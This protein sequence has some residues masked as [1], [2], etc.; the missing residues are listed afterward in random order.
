MQI[1]LL[2]IKFIFSL[3]L[4][5]RRGIA[6]LYLSAIVVIS[7]MPARDL[8]HI[9]IFPSFDKLAHFSMYFGLSFLAC[10]SLDLSRIRMGPIY[11]LL[12]GVFMWGVLMEILQRTMHNGRNF[13]FK[14][15]IANLA[16][17]LAGIVI[18][19]YFDMKRTQLRNKTSNN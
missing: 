3:K 13:D 1:I 10:W 15:M 6:M 5:L 16:G 11:L 18:Y 12:A 9:A 19:R 7:L 8:P 14:D 2:L 4:W 17:A